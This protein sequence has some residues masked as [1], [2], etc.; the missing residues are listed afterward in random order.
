[1]SGSYGIGNPIQRETHAVGALCSLREWPRSPEQSG[2]PGASV[3]TL[4]SSVSWNSSSS[5]PLLPSLWPFHADLQ[6]PRE[7]Q[8]GWR[9]DPTRLPG[10]SLTLVRIRFVSEA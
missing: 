1:M 4:G 3:G 5:S 8:G 7:E 9:R 2:F 6:A 10:S